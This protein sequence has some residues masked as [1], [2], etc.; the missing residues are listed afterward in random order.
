MLN[1]EEIEVKN[2]YIKIER[3][4]KDGDTVALGL[5]EGVYTILPP[6]DSPYFERYIAL[7]RGAITL[8]ADKR[9]S[10]IGERVL[11]PHGKVE[12]QSRDC[13]ELPYYNLSLALRQTDGRELRVVDYASAG[14]TFDK[15]S[16]C[17]AWLT[18]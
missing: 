10:N 7:R 5:D 17:A 8:A 15:A 11:L 6:C 3:E 16:E 2:G 12:A 1:G 9:I 14:S 13:P 4:W 18:R